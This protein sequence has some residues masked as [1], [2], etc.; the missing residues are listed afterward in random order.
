MAVKDWWEG[1]APHNKFVDFQCLLGLIVETNTVISFG[2]SKKN[3]EDDFK[4]PCGL[5]M[6]ENMEWFY[7]CLK[8]FCIL[9]MCCNIWGTWSHCLT[10]FAISSRMVQLPLI[11]FNEYELWMDDFSYP[12]HGYIR[13]SGSIPV[14]AWNICLRVSFSLTRASLSRPKTSHSCHWNLW[15]WDLLKKLVTKSHPFKVTDCCGCMHGGHESAFRFANN[16]SIVEGKLDSS[17]KA[18]GRGATIAGEL[19]RNF[20]HPHRFVVLEQKQMES[21]TELGSKSAGRRSTIKGQKPW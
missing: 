18:M 16:Y 6:R 7:S 21:L 1:D 9:A 20:G 5:M 11:T 13:C 8:D 10:G 3:C 14:T 17:L 15:S 4:N 19:P 12:S 2:L